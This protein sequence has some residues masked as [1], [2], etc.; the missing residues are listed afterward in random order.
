V[1]VADLIIVRRARLDLELAEQLATEEASQRGVSVGEVAPLLE[2]AL[3]E[4]RARE[5]DEGD[6]KQ[7][8]TEGQE[9]AK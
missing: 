5:N 7:A 4:L 8:T 3:V 6:T 2:A 1:S 9:R